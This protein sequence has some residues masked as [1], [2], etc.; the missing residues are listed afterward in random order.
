MDDHHDDNIQVDGCSLS[1]ITSKSERLIFTWPI[2]GFSELTTS[3]STPFFNFMEEELTDS[4]KWKVKLIPMDVD[5]QG[6]SVVTA[7]VF[8]G[9]KDADPAQ[10]FKVTIS[11]AIRT[12]D[13]QEVYKVGS[14]I[15][16]LARERYPDGGT[17]SYKATLLPWQEL[18]DNNSSLLPNN[19]LTLV[20]KLRY[21]FTEVCVR[22]D[23]I[24]DDFLNPPT[25]LSN[26]LGEALKMADF[27]DMTIVCDQKEFHCHKFILAARSEVFAAMLRH[28]FLEKQNSRVDVKEIDSE[29]MELLLNY[30]YTGQVQDFNRVSVVDLFKAA[31]RYRLDDLKHLCEEELIER[32]EASNAA[33]ILSLA[34]KYNAQPLKSFSL[35]MIS[36]NVEEVMRSPGWKELIQS[37]QTLLME[38]FDSLARYNTELKN[39]LE[40]NA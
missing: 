29:T 17:P 2:R 21:S 12:V 8:I 4:V 24:K 31:D 35:A 11:I 37:D 14:S 34:H 19:I 38:A 7:Q 30:I 39:K 22:E 15:Y 13:S 18:I 36:R 9:H 3:M 5:G 1:F 10:G 32:V 16:Y 25:S 27:T 26:D 6:N 33:D 40:K 23:G 20:V 28:E